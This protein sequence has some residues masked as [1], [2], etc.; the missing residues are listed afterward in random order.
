MSD[1]RKR[2]LCRIA[3][4]LCCALP[5]CVV[6]RWIA[7]PKSTVQWQTE[8]QALL[9]CPVSI[10]SVSTPSPSQ[11][12]FAGLRLARD[13]NRPEA[14]LQTVDYR[15]T[16]NEH[17]LELSPVTLT[18]RQFTS[19]GQHFARQ[20]S[21]IGWSG[22]PIVV[23]IPRVTIRTE[24]ETSAAET[25]FVANNCTLRLITSTRQ[26]HIA[27]EFQTD[28]AATVPVR[29]EMTRDGADTNRWSLDSGDAMLPCWLMS[30]AWPELNNV[31]EGCWFKGRLQ[32][33]SSNGNTRIACHDAQLIDLDIERLLRA[34]SG[35]SPEQPAPIS[36]VG[37]G[38]ASAVIERI[39]I[40]DGR[41]HS[42]RVDLRCVNGGRFDARWLNL[43]RESFNVAVADLGQSEQVA[44]SQL[45][46]GMDLRNGELSIFG[47]KDGLLA[48]DAQGQT[49][50]AAT[51]SSVRLS[52][53]SLAHWLA[54]DDQS[55][56]HIST[57]EL[58][59]LSRLP[60]V[61]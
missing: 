55:Q 26:T 8:I 18:L 24:N 5:T 22:Q 51:Q 29:W 23:E 1:D 12:H 7:L 34:A 28:Q 4:V 14:E 21:N 32:S 25:F 37:L 3:F 41:V 57:A 47:A 43:A 16:V 40:I 45:L 19:L 30:E 46:I 38:G 48:I 61:R 31:G 2:L 39:E 49:I 60:V 20:A 59:V 33:E 6:I 56:P 44:F 13:R 54:G 42:A 10:E 53:Q 27:W 50:A 11:V 36:V 52:P 17:R 9:G 15:W 35:R 58:N